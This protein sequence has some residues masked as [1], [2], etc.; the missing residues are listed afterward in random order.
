[1]SFN[2]TYTQYT[3][4][5][6]LCIYSKACQ[7]HSLSSLCAV[8]YMSS[9]QSPK[10]IPTCLSTTVYHS[11]VYTAHKG[12]RQLP[13]ANIQLHISN[14][15]LKHEV[16]IMSRLNLSN[17]TERKSKTRAMIFLCGNMSSH[18]HFTKTFVCVCV[19]VK[20]S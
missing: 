11:E 16:C 10:T 20:M 9:N 8:S 17:F 6:E 4:M 14:A 13:S 12:R 2:L 5:Q 19:R 3:N 15:H 7:H 18:R 1:M